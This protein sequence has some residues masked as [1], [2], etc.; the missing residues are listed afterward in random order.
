M[1]NF[2]T[3]PNRALSSVEVDGN[4]V[5]CVTSKVHIMVWYPLLGMKVICH[6][7]LEAPLKIGLSVNYVSSLAGQEFNYLFPQFIFYDL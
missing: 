4:N 3:F 6:I 5:T 2:L 1:P 7:H